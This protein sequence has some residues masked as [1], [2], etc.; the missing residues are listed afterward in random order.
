MSNIDWSKE[1]DKAIEY[2]DSLDGKKFE[3]FLLSCASDYVVDTN[4]SQIQISEPV[5][6][7]CNLKIAKMDSFY[8]DNISMAA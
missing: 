6:F 1:V 7:G 5:P 3:D 4:Y 8:T 2:I